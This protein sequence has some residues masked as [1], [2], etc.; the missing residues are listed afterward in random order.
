MDKY[1]SAIAYFEDAVRE[2]DEIIEDCSPNLQAELIEQKKHFVVALAALRAQAEREKPPVALTLELLK[3]IAANPGSNNWVWI[4]A[5]NGADD[6]NVKKGYYRVAA[7]FTDGEAFCFGWPGYTDAL[8]Y[9]GYGTKWLAYDRP[10][11]RGA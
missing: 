5:M 11:E 2:T 10:P 9:S 3:D 8:D 4:Q 1:Q 6:V 7:D